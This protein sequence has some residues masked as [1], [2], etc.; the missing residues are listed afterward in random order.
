MAVQARAWAPPKEIFGRFV[1]DHLPQAVFGLFFGSESVEIDGKLMG[2]CRV[3][4]SGSC[5]WIHL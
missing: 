3:S 2:F 5:F 1:S 4:S